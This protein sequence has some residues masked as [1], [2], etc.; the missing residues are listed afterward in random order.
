MFAI[1]GIVLLLIQAYTRPQEFIEPIRELPFLYLFL[2][3]ALF[4]YAVDLR[5][6]RTRPVAAPQLGWVVLFGLW[7]LFSIGHRL[8]SEIST[9]AINIAV[10]LTFF[11]LVAHAVQSFRALSLVAGTVLVIALFLA[12]V[13]VHQGLSPYGCIRL[14]PT[15]ADESGVWDGRACN[16]ERECDGGDAEPD[17]EY[18]CERVGLFGTSSVGHG[19]VRYR[20]SLNDPNELSLTLCV[21]LPFAFAFFERKRSGARL[22]VLVASVA[23]IALCTIMTKSR[24]GQLVF[25]AVLG[26]YFVK[27]FG[28]RGLALGALVAAPILLLGGRHGEG[29]TESSQERIEMMYQAMQLFRWYPLRG[30]GFEQI[31]EY[32]R[33]TAHNSYALAA[34][35]MGFPGLLLWTSVLY[36]SFKT[37][38]SALV[39]FEG[40][41][42]ARPARAWSMAL[43]ASLVGM[44]VGVFFLSF[45]Y[46][47]VFWV[48]IG[49]CGGLYQACRAHDPTFRVTLDRR[50]LWRLVAIDLALVVVIFT[51]TG[52]KVR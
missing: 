25:L 51:Y 13:G 50:D 8:P 20:G 30:V 15:A 14:D 45:D 23:L 37:V 47:I 40:D 26:T 21:A 9:Y 18:A 36:A 11:F 22:F 12:G 17:S 19:R 6:R 2:G 4:G 33:L 16:N 29:A 5:L 48:Y 27:R 46:H 49:L 3:L 38:L 35:E 34:A 42:A 41:P 43:L 28:V 7:A 32:N 52:L 31:L 39:R 10:P 24:G 1:P 44:A